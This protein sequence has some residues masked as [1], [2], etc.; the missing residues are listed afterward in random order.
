LDAR[1]VLVSIPAGFT[2]MQR[3]DAS[4][5]LAWRLAV[6]EVFRG[7]FARGYRV[8]DF[9]ADPDGGRYLLEV[10]ANF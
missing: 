9:W 4:R 2:E 7:Y 5:A 8:V 1:R 3:S 10:P 6:R